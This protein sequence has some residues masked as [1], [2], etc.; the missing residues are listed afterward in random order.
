MKRL[1]DCNASDFK[2]MNAAQL[3]QSIAASEGR[4]MLSEVI[5][6]VSPLYPQVTNAEMAGA[7]GADLLLFNLFDVFHPKVEGFSDQEDYEVIHKLK[8]MTGRPI[9]LNLEPVDQ[10]ADAIESLLEL[11]EGRTA[12][13]ASF[14]KVKELGFDFV[15]LTG[16][17]KTG[18]TNKAIIESIKLASNILG[19]DVLI[20][21]GK[22]HGAGVR[23]DIGEGII[24]DDVLTDFIDSGADVILLP[25][26]GT[27]PGIT[28]DSMVK[29]VRVVR[30]KGALT[31]LT[32]GTSQEGA[33]EDTIR[34]IA[35]QN[36]MVGAD[37][38]HIGDAG[39][40]GIAAPENIL[41]YSIAIRG[42]RHTYIRMASS[43]QR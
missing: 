9:G 41:A 25:S 12:S 24:S 11:P 29:K 13:E 43:S 17:P 36:K 37:I 38:H 20:M 21:A 27:V 23:G 15:C 35:L 30:E 1:L 14:K 10:S 5:T 16:N 33:D 7:F 32:I 42:K 18:V 26:P 28:V 22:M 19:D 39:Y 8:E 4:V 6:S 3:K 31:M 40:S 34:Q 2:K